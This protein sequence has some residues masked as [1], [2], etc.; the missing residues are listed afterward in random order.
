MPLQALFP[1]PNK[2]FGCV[3]CLPA[4]RLLRDGCVHDIPHV[5]VIDV[6][7]DLGVVDCGWDGLPNRKGFGTPLPREEGA[8][9]IVRILIIIFILLYSQF[10]PARWL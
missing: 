3:L 10:V 5:L 4:E 6:G 9:F 8:L 2:E 1:C 7:W